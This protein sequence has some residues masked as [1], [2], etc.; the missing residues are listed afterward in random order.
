MD[1]LSKAG[2]MMGRVRSR[3]K[4]RAAQ[5]NGRKGGRKREKIAVKQEGSKDRRLGPTEEKTKAGLHE[6]GNN[7]L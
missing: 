1:E 5:I 3:R 2:R 6:G 7:P 4:A